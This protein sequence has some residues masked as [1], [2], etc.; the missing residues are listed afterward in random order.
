MPPGKLSAHKVD[1]RPGLP[2]GERSPSF[3]VCIPGIRPPNLEPFFK[4]P[5]PYKFCKLSNW[6]KQPAFLLL[7]GFLL[8]TWILGLVQTDGIQNIQF[9][10]GPG[11][12]AFAPMSRVVDGWRAVWVEHILTIITWDVF[13]NLFQDCRQGLSDCCLTKT[14]RRFRVSGLGG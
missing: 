9:L 8:W 1:S 6:C 5:K 11:R 10:V 3:R 14:M 7:P 12:L 13:L 2:F 4:N